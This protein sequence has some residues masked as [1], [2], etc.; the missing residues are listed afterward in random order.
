MPDDD[1]NGNSHAAQWCRDECKKETSP[2]CT[3]FHV[4]YTW[5]KDPV[6]KSNECHM[7]SGC[8]VIKDTTYD[9]QIKA[10]EIYEMND[11][12]LECPGM[13]QAIS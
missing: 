5:D 3:H 10:Y 9:D 8:S 4:L 2:K 13:K 6:I 11:D 1:K 7:Y 12:E